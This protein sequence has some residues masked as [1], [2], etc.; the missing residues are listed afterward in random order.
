MPTVQDVLAVK[1]AVV[2][3]ISP[4]ATVLEATQKMNQHRLGALLVMDDGQVAGIFT[5]RDVLRRVVA[6]ERSPADTRVIDVMTANVIC[7]DADDE[8]DEI[9]ALMQQRKIR[10][11]PVCDSNGRIKGMISIGDVNAYHASNQEMH[12]N[13]LSE[14]IYGRV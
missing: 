14:Y 10:H 3:S 4:D 7:C 11:V 12:I 6:E 13:F 2:Q 9:S 5:E 1:G 8:L